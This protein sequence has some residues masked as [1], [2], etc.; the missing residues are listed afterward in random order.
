M[1][2]QPRLRAK[3]DWLSYLPRRI[4]SVW[5]GQVLAAVCLLLA[6]G[7]HRILI[8]LLQSN[9]PFFTLFPAVL[10]AAIWGGPLSGFTTLLVGAVIASYFWLPPYFSFFVAEGIVP[11]ILGFLLVG[12]VVLVIAAVLRSLVDRQQAAEERAVLLAQEMRHRVRNLMGLVV[13]ISHQTARQTESLPEFLDSFGGRMEA[14]SAALTLDPSCAEEARVMELDALLARVLAP[15]GHDRCLFAGPMIPIGGGVASALA[16]VLHELATNAVK[17]GALSVPE[18]RVEIGWRRGGSHV[19]VEWREIG[20][21]PVA[22]PAGKGFGSRLIQSAFAQYG[23]AV[24]I[25]YAAEGVHCRI[26]F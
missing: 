3:R 24:T 20:G 25:T 23:G 5:Q 1:L 13:A 6:F 26:R 18:G 10:V 15:F 8:P 2:K 22:N 14:L 9:G 19:E 21:P 12:G 17:Y 7:A 11:H 4:R 16:L